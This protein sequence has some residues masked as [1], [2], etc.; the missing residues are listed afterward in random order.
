VEV[1]SAIAGQPQDLAGGTATPQRAADRGAHAGL[2]GSARRRDGRLQI[3]YAG[4]PVYYY[5]GDRRP[6]EILCQAATEFGG[7]WYVVAPGGNAIR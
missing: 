1:R 7:T 5:V 2:L 3:T 6:Q 4:H